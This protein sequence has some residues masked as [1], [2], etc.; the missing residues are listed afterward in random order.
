MLFAS[1]KVSTWKEFLSTKK[2]MDER[3]K[4]RSHNLNKRKIGGA[5]G[6][7]LSKTRIEEDSDKTKSRPGFEGRKQ[8]FLNNKHDQ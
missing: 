4:I 3:Q 1:K 5:A 8:G 2:K 6:A 7:N